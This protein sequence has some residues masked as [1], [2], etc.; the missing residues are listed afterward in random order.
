M[1]KLVILFVILM[2]VFIASD[3][4]AQL[5]EVTARLTSDGLI[6]AKR[7]GQDLGICGVYGEA[8]GTNQATCLIYD[9]TAA[10][11]KAFPKVIVPAGEFNAGYVLSD[12]I[13]VNTGMYLDITGTNAACWVIY[14]K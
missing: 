6:Y 3:V 8:D 4:L 7:S 11:G 9:N 12:C 14:A 13:K 2:A 10:S 5:R 1:K